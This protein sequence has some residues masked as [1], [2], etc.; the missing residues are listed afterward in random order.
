MRVQQPRQAFTLVELLVVISIIGILMGLLLPAVQYSREA[1]RR[2]SC[3]NNLK[4]LA[5]GLQN[6]HDAHRAF[7]A[8][9][10]DLNGSEHSWCTYALPYVEQGNVYSQI[11][12]DRHWKDPNGNYAA[13]SAILPVF[14]CPS[15]TLD[16]PGDADYAGI[17]GSGLTG[18]GW[19]GSYAGGILTV[20][21]ANS[22]SAIRVAD[23]TDGLSNT[24][25]IAESADRS[26][27]DH[28][29]WADGLQIIS[30]NVE[31]VNLA[32]G[33]IFS[34]HRVGAYAARADGGVSFLSNST[35]KYVIGALC[36]RSGG[37][38][39]SLEF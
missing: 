31:S 16:F 33:E 3:Q 25:F 12:L 27:E 9:R 36:T 14:R 10:Y 11:R 8:G 1:G 19:V 4:N 7:P 24:V 17:M 21:D 15:S 34:R 38:L 18:L 28:G 22:P 23:I 29:R 32:P 26:E 30:H 39:I 5:L 35:D 20:V 6:F 37:E 2:M 13:T